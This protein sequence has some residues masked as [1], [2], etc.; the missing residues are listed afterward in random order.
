MKTLYIS[1]GVLLIAFIIVQIYVMRAKNIETYPYVVNKNTTH[2][3]SAM[4][5]VLFTSVKLSTKEYKEA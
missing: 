2:L 3:K 5:P 1:L 4:R